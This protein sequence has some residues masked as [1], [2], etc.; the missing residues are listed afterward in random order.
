MTDEAAAMR[1]WLEQHDLAEAE[2]L[3]HL[4]NH[5]PDGSDRL[6][7]AER[8]LLSAL[9]ETR[10][11][12][13][14]GYRPAPCDRLT[15]PDRADPAE[16]IGLFDPGSTRPLERA[17]VEPT[18]RHARPPVRLAARHRAAVPPGRRPAHRDRDEERER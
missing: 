12:V 14:P 5:G 10:R 6:T 11:T 16:L 4:P 3:H 7:D 15:N 2:L 18:S 13:V 1:A 17:V 9:L 8:Q